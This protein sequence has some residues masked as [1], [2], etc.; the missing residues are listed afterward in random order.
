MNQT[1]AERNVWFFQYSL[2][3]N[4]KNGILQ[5]T[6]NPKMRRIKVSMEEFLIF[7][8]FFQNRRTN[9]PIRSLM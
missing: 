3:K 8:F 7:F 2:S 9:Y 4:L 6:G 5:I 1:G